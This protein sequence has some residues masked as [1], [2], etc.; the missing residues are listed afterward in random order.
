MAKKQKAEIA[1]SRDPDGEPSLD[2]YLDAGNQI[3]ISVGGDGCISWTG[4]INS[5]RN[6][7]SILDPLGEFLFRLLDKIARL[8][9]EDESIRREA[10]IS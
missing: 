3:S 2:I 9:S 5:K 8:D 4:I 1:V 10:G 7:G 6:H